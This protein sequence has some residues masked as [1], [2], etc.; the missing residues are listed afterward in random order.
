MPKDL[1]K[2]SLKDLDIVSDGELEQRMRWNNGRLELT[3]SAV[4]LPDD[5]EHDR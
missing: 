1:T 2:L 4:G 3:V 5:E